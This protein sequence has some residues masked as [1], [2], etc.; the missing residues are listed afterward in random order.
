[1]TSPSISRDI[2]FDPAR[3][4]RH[5]QKKN[6]LARADDICTYMQK[7]S[8]YLF[9]NTYPSY[10]SLDDRFGREHPLSDSR[11]LHV[12]LRLPLACS[13]ASCERE[14]GPPALA[15]EFHTAH[16][17][18]VSQTSSRSLECCLGTACRWKDLEAVHWL[19]CC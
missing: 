8:T 19:C 10:S 15:S 9:H 16:N 12:Y 13:E 6:S 1:M 2:P 11:Q 18:L 17:T 7:M 5:T 3:A 4:I 14:S